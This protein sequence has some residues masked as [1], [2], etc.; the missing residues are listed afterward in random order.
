[1]AWLQ[2][3]DSVVGADSAYR[4]RVFTEGRTMSQG[5]IVVEIYDRTQLTQLGAVSR[6]FAMRTVRSRG[7]E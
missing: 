2:D 6:Q 7:R 4:W 1:M 3:G 5:K